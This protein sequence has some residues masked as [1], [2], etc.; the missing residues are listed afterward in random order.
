MKPSRATSVNRVLFLCTGNYYRSRF[1]EVYFNHLASS[2]GLAWKADS[3]GLAIDG[4]NYG[5]ISQHTRARLQSLGITCATVE[6]F[7]RPL[8]EADL[9]SADLVIAV[10]ESEHRWIFERNFSS[11]RDEIE[12][13][14]VHDLDCAGPEEAIPQLMREVEELVER[15]W[16]ERQAA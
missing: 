13:W 1:A 10:K 14:H 12:Y 16:A 3:R 9:A 11:W 4:C 7:P 6:R 5:P 15:L 2:R 8:S